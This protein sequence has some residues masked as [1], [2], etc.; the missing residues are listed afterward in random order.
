MIEIEATLFSPKVTPSSL[1]DSGIASMMI[2][3]ESLDSYFISSIMCIVNMVSCPKEESNNIF[4][5]KMSKSAAIC[6]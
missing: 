3:E 5:D 2:N 6:K 1:A 4:D